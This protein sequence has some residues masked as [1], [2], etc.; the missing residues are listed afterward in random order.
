MDRRRGAEGTRSD[1]QAPQSHRPEA[2]GARARA[3]DRD[4]ARERALRRFCERI[5]GDD[6]AWHACIH[7]PEND[8]DAR[9]FHA[10]VVYTQFAPE[11]EP[12]RARWTFEDE[13]SVPP[14]AQTI[15]TLSGNQKVKGDSALK[16]RNELIRDWRT[17]WADIQ[18]DELDAVGAN[19]VY[20]PRSYRDQGRPD[21][22]PGKHRGTAQSAMERRGE[23]A[24]ATATSSDAEWER[25]AAVVADALDVED[26]RAD[27]EDSWTELLPEPVR[28]A[29]ESVRLSN[30]LEGTDDELREALQERLDTLS[31]REVGSGTERE[32]AAAD[33]LRSLRDAD[34]DARVP[35][36]SA[37]IE[38]W[39]RIER[40]VPDDSERARRAQ[41]IVVA[42]S[43]AEVRDTADDPRPKVRRLR[44]A[45]RQSVFTQRR[46]RSHLGELRARADPAL[47]DD[48]TIDTLLSDLREAGVSVIAAF[49]REEARALAAERALSRTE[50]GLRRITH[51]VRTGEPNQRCRSELLSLRGPN[52]RT[53]A[54]LPKEDFDSL[55]GHIDVLSHA[56]G[57]RAQTANAAANEAPRPMMM[58]ARDIALLYNAD[59]GHNVTGEQIKRH[60][61]A[62]ALLPKTERDDITQAASDAATVMASHRARA[63][64]AAEATRRLGTP[65]QRRDDPARIDALAID[66]PLRYDL[67]RKLPALAREVDEEVFALSRRRA[68]LGDELT[69]AENSADSN[70]QNAGKGLERLSHR[71]G[72]ELLGAN[73]ALI[74]HDEPAIHA[75]LVEHTRT[76]TR[77]AARA[78]TRIERDEPEE[79]ASLLI[80]RMCTERQRRAMRAALAKDNETI[81]RIERAIEEERLAT[82]RL[83]LTIRTL[84]RSLTLDD[85]V[86]TDDQATRRWRERHA[87]LLESSTAERREK[88]H[89]LLSRPLTVERLSRREWVLA[90]RRFGIFGAPKPPPPVRE[91]EPDTATER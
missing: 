89:D 41:Q 88:A 64:L 5:F 22:T 27:P 57:L 19:K 40:T 34:D 86:D 71:A 6:V 76:F 39:D 35:Q 10:H 69:E 42:W 17:A 37:S 80:S 54:L 24:V 56:I 8:N 72:A 46:W 32:R 33:W 18:N 13:N 50:K 84:A 26:M 21:L 30:G 77:A 45:A 44:A 43:D 65:R 55:T 3:R 74:A 61:A 58:L 90:A 62:M 38:H 63:R 52:I 83:R 85:N 20:D 15:K 4:E 25:L 49:G 60:R 73:P 31:T 12:S 75:V 67:A 81:E 28:D 82:E 1:A 78:I 51:Q 9:N 14:P 36:D 11:R 7:T 70:P 16:F 66:E 87:G 47:L 29:F 23:A 91:R 2:H 53:L 68:A 48:E 79:R 59:P